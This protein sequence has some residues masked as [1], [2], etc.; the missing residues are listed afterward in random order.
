MTTGRPEEKQNNLRVEQIVRATVVEGGL[1]RAML[2]LRHQRFN[3][4]T[5]QELQTGQQLELQVLTTH[6]KLSFKI[7]TIPFESR[8]VTLLPLLAKSF[9]WNGLL[10][11]IQQGT[12]MRP[13][14]AKQEAQP[15][16]LAKQ[17]GQ[18]PEPTKPGVQPP[19]SVKQWARQP[20]PVRQALKQ[21]STLLRPV[22][23]LPADEWK[24]V[25]VTLGQLK[26]SE[27]LFS[28]SN[29]PALAAAFDRVI[30]IFSQ[31]IDSL[32]LPQQLKLMAQQLRQQPELMHQFMAVEQ[33][34]VSTLLARLEQPQQSLQPQQARQLATELKALLLARPAAL[35]QTLDRTALPQTLNRTAQDLTELL[36]PSPVVNPKPSP[37]LL[38]HLKS[39]VVQLQIAVGEKLVWPQELQQVVQQVLDTVGP[40]VTTPEILVQGGKLGLLAQL[41]GLN[42]EAELLRGRTREALS[43]LKLALLGEQ[44]KLGPKGEEA[45]HRIELFQVC[46]ARLAEQN[47]LFVPLPLSF[48]EEGF[49]LVEGDGQQDDL[50]KSKN[51]TTQMSLHLRMSALGNLRIDMLSEPSGLL[52]RVACEDR[53]RAEFLQSLSG[54]LKERLKDLPIRGISFTIGA[55]L[56]V[57]ELLEKIVP[58]AQGILDARV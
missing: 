18:L 57:R 39:L 1:D 41:F 24:A 56:P 52:L 35:S 15:L 30:S 55:K 20:E 53:H 7:L 17:G 51:G 27:P 31:Q 25:A 28:V 37:A 44:K 33:K 21:L 45:L 43:S 50:Q 10:Q 34:R 58:H 40:L 29:G 48:L 13:E 23:D 32:D 2:E 9:D 5:G 54:Q 8:L 38:G 6:P 26:R 22:A 3:I 19:G 4:Q 11:Q 16:E 12:V 49:L 46:R 47:L 36:S 42:L 14:S